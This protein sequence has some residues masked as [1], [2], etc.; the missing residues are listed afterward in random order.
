M[1]EM[2]EIDNLLNRLVN[3]FEKSERNCIG[4]YNEYTPC[5]KK[6]GESHKSKRYRITQRAGIYGSGCKEEDGFIVKKKCDKENDGIIPCVLGQ[7]CSEN[8]DCKTKNC[9]PVQKVCIR[10]S[11]CS[12]ENLHL[13]NKLECCLLY[14]SPSPRD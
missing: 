6:C 1:I 14:T 9:D 4:G 11:K 2:L 3:V 5:D 12:I 8:K 13:C 7:T 10:S